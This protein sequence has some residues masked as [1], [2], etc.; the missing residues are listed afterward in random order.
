MRLVRGDLVHSTAG[1]CG[2][3]LERVDL[4]SRDLD[5]ECG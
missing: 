1:Q 4:G 2:K 5:I 3:L